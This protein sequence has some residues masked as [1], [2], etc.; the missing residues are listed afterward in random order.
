M[1]FEALT[2]CLKG[3]YYFSGDDPDGV[4]PQAQGTAL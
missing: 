3:D 4:A 1:L 2:P